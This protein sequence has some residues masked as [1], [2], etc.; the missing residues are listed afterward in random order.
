[1][2]YRNVCCFIIFTL[3]FFCYELNK[4][5]KE[6]EVIIADQEEILEQQNSTIIYQ[7]ATIVKLQNALNFATWNRHYQNNQNKSIDPVH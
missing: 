3:L 2:D 1:M 4:K 6:L 5:N 7:N